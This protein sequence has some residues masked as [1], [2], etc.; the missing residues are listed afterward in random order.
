MIKVT[1]KTDTDRDDPKEVFRL[2]AINR[3]E[4][5]SMCAVVSRL[6]DNKKHRY[7][8]VKNDFSNG[9]STKFMEVSEYAGDIKV[10]PISKLK[11]VDSLTDDELKNDKKRYIKE[12]Y[13]LLN[14]EDLIV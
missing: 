13:L 12:L 10:I 8:E 3:T 7:V 9:M 1:L 14:N 5:S 6:F 4:N 11:V 2:L